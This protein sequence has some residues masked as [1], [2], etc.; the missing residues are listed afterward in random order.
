MHP[1]LA[2]SIEEDDVGDPCKPER[3]NKEMVD[4]KEG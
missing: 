3:L 1:V 2:D 4:K